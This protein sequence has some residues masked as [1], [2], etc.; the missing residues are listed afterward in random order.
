MSP[1]L[2][3]QDLTNRFF[4]FNAW[5]P[6]GKGN[7]LLD[8]QKLQK[9]PI[10]RISVDILQNTNFFKAFTISAN[11]PTIYI[12]Q[13]WNTL[14]HDAKTGIYSFQLDEQLF[15]L[16][17]DLLCKALEITLVDSAHP[18]V[19]PLAGH[20]VMDFVDELGYPEE[21]HFVSKMHQ[22]LEM[23]ARKPTAKKGRQKKKTSKVDKPKRPTPVKQPALV[24][25]TKPMK[26]KTSKPTPLKKIHKGKVMKVCKEKRSDRLVDEEDEEPQPAS[27]PHVEDDEYNLQRGITQRLLVVEGKGKGIATDEQVAHSLLE[28]QKPK[29]QSTTNQYIF[30]RR[31]PVTQDAPTGPSAQPRD[32]TSTNVV[33]DTPS[34]ADVEIGADTEKSNSEGNIEILN[35]D[36]ERGENISN[37]A[38]LE[39]RTVELDE[40][41][42][43]S[44]PGNTLESPHP[45]DEDQTGSNPR[46]RHVALAGPNPKPMHEDFIAIVYPQVHESLKHTT[47]EHIHI[48]NPL[49]SSET[50]SSMK[51][52]DDALTFGDQFLNDKPTKEDSG[53]ANVETEVESMVTVSIHQAPSSA[54][55][56]S[57]P[58]IDLTPPKPI[59]PSAQEPVFTAKTATTTTTLLPP[60][61]PQ[62]QSTTVPELATRYLALEKI[63]AN[64]E[65]KYKLQDKTTQALSSRMFESGSYRSQPEH[66]ALYDAL[67]VSMDRKNREE[68]IEATTSS[69]WKTSDI[70]ESPSSSSKQ[71]TA[72]QSEQPVDDV[73]IPYD[74]HISD[75]EDTGV[76]HLPKIKTKTDWL[77]P[78]PKEERLE[79]PEP[80]WAVPSIDLP[81]TEN[82]WANAIS[83]TYKDL[84]E[85]KL[86]RKTRDM[87][88]FIK[89]YCKHIGKSKLSKADLEDQID[90]VNL[91]GNWVVPDV[92]KPLTLGGLPG[93]VII[94]PQYFFNKD[95]EYLVSGD[96]E[97][98]NALSISKLKA[99][100]YPDFGLEELVPSLWIECER[101]YDISTAYGISHWWF[102]RKEFYITRHSAPFDRYTFGSHMKILSVVSLKTFSLY[103]YT[104][105]REVV[106]HRADYKEYKISEA[107]FKNL[108]PNDF[109][110]LYLLHL[111][112]NLNHLSSADKVHLFNAVNLWIRNIVIKQ[113]VE[114]LQLGIESYQTKLNLT[115][116]SWDATDFLFKEDYTIV[117]KPRA[118]MYRDR[119]NQ[120]KM[121]TESEV[122]K[123]S[124]GTLTIILEKLDHI[125]KYYMLFKFNPGM[126]HRIWSEDD[127]SKSKEFIEIV[128]MD[129]VTQCTTFPNHSRSLNRLLFH[130]SRR[131]THF[132]RLSHSELV[133]IEK[134]AVR[135]SLLSLKPKCTIESKAKRSSINLIRILFQCT[136]LSHT[137]KARNI[138]RVL[139][140][141]LVVLPEHP[142]DT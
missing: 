73:L 12:Q 40:G 84:E 45:P 98:R 118:I 47:E 82:N 115:Q 125:V 136:F 80:D 44:D 70:R 133:D 87:G 92:G 10:F 119:N 122:Q 110:D 63:C 59:S 89:W 17:V 65:K 130:F 105:L 19:S 107:D 81:E 25:Q 111:Q 142:S 114:D 85:N 15:I 56:L 140:I 139:R 95:L 127:K 62:Q 18:F 5:L 46:Q 49:S 106:L 79:T 11:V 61:P 66:A 35:V 117:N 77:K 120:K 72:S 126:E 22:Y 94:Q 116:P 24:E 38:A 138:L 16:I 55:P 132:Y 141:I 101:E 48:E 93:Q 32:D 3:L 96:K 75:S 20:Q 71:K 97:R 129:P 58:I 109:E 112:G 88:S 69:T 99:A 78:V 102:K 13:F 23:V 4:L 26:E 86:I 135:S 42:A 39:E 8:L 31:I 68:F 100:Y 104:F 67:E 30:Q 2:L 134:V 36:K 27:K 43:G 76:A 41:Q 21:I 83:N 124:D 128:V 52:L 33:R 90:L 121:M 1:L 74:V 108:H 54:P 37:T 9:N 131:F 64:F 14:V 60:P 51:N 57:T 91:E 137:M 50:L 29:K 28:L 103:G 34:P 113:R 123:F 7:L 53:K 6:V